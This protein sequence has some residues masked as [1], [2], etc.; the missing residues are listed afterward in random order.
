[1][2]ALRIAFFRA[3]NETRDGKNENGFWKRGRARATRRFISNKCE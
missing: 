2:D 3:K 1:M